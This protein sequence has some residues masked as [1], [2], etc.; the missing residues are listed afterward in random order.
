MPEAVCS[1]TALEQDDIESI[2]VDDGSA[3]EGTHK[4]MHALPHRRL[5]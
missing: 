3:D 1:T 4:E 2:A 5:R